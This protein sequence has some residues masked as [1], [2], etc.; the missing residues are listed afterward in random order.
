MAGSASTHLAPSPIPLGALRGGDGVWRWAGRTGARLPT[1]WVVLCGGVDLRAFTEGLGANFELHKSFCHYFSRV[2]CEFLSVISLWSPVA[3]C[4][5]YR[6][7]L[8]PSVWRGSEIL[9]TVPLG[10]H[11][12]AYLVLCTICAIVVPFPSRFQFIM[13]PASFQPVR[14]EQLC[15]SVI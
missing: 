9:P 11:V 5:Q 1:E 6:A 10:A 14:Q 2:T 15:N 12:G 3:R 8:A 7:N 13:S 4:Y